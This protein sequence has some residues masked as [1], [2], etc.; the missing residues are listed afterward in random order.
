[1]E[2]PAILVAN[3]QRREAREGADGVVLDASVL[4]C[5]RAS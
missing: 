3:V 2:V 1:M 4:T 5:R